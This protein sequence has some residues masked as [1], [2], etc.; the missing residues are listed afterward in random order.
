ME[1][2]YL[3]R[4]IIIGTQTFGRDTEKNEAF[5]MLNMLLHLGTIRIDTAE[6]YPFPEKIKSIGNTELIIGEWIKSENVPR[7]AV[8]ISTK[9]S[10]RS[11]NGWF[12][13]G[14]RLTKR[15]IHNAVN[16]SLKRLGVDYIDN[17]YLHWPDRYTNIFGRKYYH[18][19][20]DNLYIPIEEQR[21]ALIS[22]VD[23]GKIGSYS[24]SN[25]TPW[26]VMKFIEGCGEQSKYK[27]RYIQ[28]EY[29]I[30]QRQ[31]ETSLL[32]ISLRESIPL[33]AY[34]PLAFGLL[35][36]KYSD[37][38]NNPDFRLVKNKLASGRYLSDENFDTAD[39][40]NIICKKYGVP[41]AKFSLNYVAQKNFIDGV[42]LGAKKECQL[43]ELIN[44]IYDPLDPELIKE[45]CGALESFVEI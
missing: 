1:H 14:G 3:T 23:S 28:N 17:Y 29:S 5:K 41:T 7:H 22:L 2:E 39:K 32:E 20:R 13:E 10:G 40:V 27:P 15:R 25:E 6:R 18:P 19:D 8:N 36:G 44:Y 43:R 33:I 30:L 11:D 4:K 16:A 24:L 21:Q 12:E 38:R 31:F 42:I 37:D 45:I 26:G 35:T 9:V 34:S